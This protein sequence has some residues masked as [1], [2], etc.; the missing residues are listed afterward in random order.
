MTPPRPN[1]GVGGRRPTTLSP[2]TA[3]NQ[4][5][6]YSIG[7]D[8]QGPVAA[9]EL[10]RLADA[11]TLKPTDLVWKDGMADWAQ[12]RSIKGLFAAAAPAAAPAAARA[13]EPAADRSRKAEAQA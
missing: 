3:V 4:E 8:R 10:K 9:A 12:A 5:W 1:S 13:T 6:Y 2:G 11:G 7:G